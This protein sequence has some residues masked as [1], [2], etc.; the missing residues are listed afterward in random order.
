VTPEPLLASNVPS[1]PTKGLESLASLP[2]GLLQLRLLL[3]AI[4]VA[5]LGPRRHDGSHNYKSELKIRALPG[6]LPEQPAPRQRLTRPSPP[7]EAL[8]AALLQVSTAPACL[9]AASP[10]R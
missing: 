9:A 3:A 6:Q 8:H 5:F 7:H 2:P 4:L 10:P 1:L